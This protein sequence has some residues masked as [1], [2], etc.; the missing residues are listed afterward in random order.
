MAEPLKAVEADAKADEGVVVALVTD[1]ATLN[2][3]I[4]P[5]PMW[6]DGAVEKLTRGDITGWVHLACDDKDVIAEWDATP[7]R[8]RDLTA[9]VEEWTRLTGEDL[10]KSGASAPSSKSTRKR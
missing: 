6:W 7:K 10:G 3:P 5:P 1:N 9:F 8:Y 2:V 4:G